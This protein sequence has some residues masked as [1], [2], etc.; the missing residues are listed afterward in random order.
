ME[1]VYG[2]GYSNEQD[3]DLFYSCEDFFSPGYFLIQSRFQFKRE[4]KKEKARILNALHILYVS[5]RAFEVK[6]SCIM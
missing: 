2:Y 5:F 4:R 1:S 3:I 6:I